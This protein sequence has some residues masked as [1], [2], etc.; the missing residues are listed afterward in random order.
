MNNYLNQS[1]NASFDAGN[2]SRRRYF[3]IIFVYFHIY[4][5]L[6]YLTFSSSRFI[7]RKRF[8][9]EI[10]EY[11]LGL[12]PQ[13]LNRATGGVT[14]R[15]RTQST[16]FNVSGDSQLTPISPMTPMTPIPAPIQAAIPAL[17][18]VQQMG[19]NSLL[20]NDKRRPLK[21]NKKNKRQRGAP[22]GTNKDLGRWKPT[23]DLSL[24]IGIQQTN[25]IRSVHRGIKFSCKFTY[26][27]LQNRWYSLLY[28]ESI[29]RIAVTAMRNL[30]PEMVESVQ[31]KALYTKVEEELL[32]TIR[33]SDRPTLENFQELLS[34]NAS[35]FYPARTPKA[36]MNHW[37]LM[38]QYTLLPDQ[39]VLVRFFIKLFLQID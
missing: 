25:D 12:P 31:S 24:I 39:T 35:S 28:D 38:K 11:S 9:D 6:F 30:H 8:D 18:L 2:S 37:Q 33:S 14:S 3:I 16:S 7:K 20:N 5:H 22:F 1:L 15:S 34:K 36:L 23:D 21:L 29:S 13:Q 32:C 26:Q 10:V 17:N 19:A 27:E 4:L